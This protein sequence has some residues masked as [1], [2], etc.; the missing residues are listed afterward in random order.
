MIDFVVDTSVLVDV[1]LLKDTA[2]ELRRSVMTGACAAPELLDLETANVLRR[3][4]IRDDLPPAEAFETLSDIR[5]APVLRVGHRHLVE[6][7]W[8]L[9][10][11][12]STYDAAYVALAEMLGVPLLTLDARLGRSSGHRVE[13]VVYPG[14]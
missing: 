8:A 7:V 11:N 13:V 4:V 3:M 2:P 5:D 10:Q 1:F 12:V 6:R 14:S 9:R